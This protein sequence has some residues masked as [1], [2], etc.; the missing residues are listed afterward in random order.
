ML[1]LNPVLASA[2]TLLFA[3]KFSRSRFIDWIRNYR[4]TVIIAVPT[5]V[6]LLLEETMGCA[7]TAFYGVRFVSCSTAPLMPE[8]HR[9]S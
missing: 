9:P 7:A 3:K 6:N 4:P 5:V 8:Q 1:S 2:A